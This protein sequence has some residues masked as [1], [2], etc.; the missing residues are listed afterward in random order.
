VPERRSGPARLRKPFK[1][2]VDEHLPE[3]AQ[4]I[5]SKDLRKSFHMLAMVE[6]G[7]DETALDFYMGHAGSSIGRRHY[8]VARAGWLR[9]EVAD[10]V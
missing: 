3:G 1:T 8:S 5:T 6:C 9:S 4:V 7:C 10:K 2:Y